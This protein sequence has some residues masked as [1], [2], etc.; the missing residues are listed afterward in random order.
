MEQTKIETILRLMQMLIG[1][2]RTTR[3]LANKLGC[4]VRTVQRYINQL[5]NAH[6]VV[7]SRQRGI[8]YLSTSRGPLKDIS[9][10]IHFSDEEAY[11]LQK[12]IDSIDDNTTLKQNLKQKLYNIYNYVELADV[13]VH[14][15]QGE[16]V[17]NLISAIDEHLCVELVDYRSANSNK[18]SNRLVEPFAFTTNYQQV[19]CFEHESQ[20]SKLFKVARIGKVRILKDK[21]WIDETKHIKPHIDIFRIAGERYISN[22]RL[23]LNIRSYNLLVEE[24]PLAEEY[25]TQQSDNEYLLDAPLCSYEGVC[26]FILGLFNDIKVLGDKNLINHLNQKILQLKPITTET[27]VKGE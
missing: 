24:Y 4:N 7:E 11:I 2:R 17:Q 12:A 13:V 20:K 9:D 5:R 10:L 27:V 3:E 18:V 8:Y 21:P 19:W 26:R 23:L 22:A 14:P 6:F 15:E 1:N 25:I 16:V